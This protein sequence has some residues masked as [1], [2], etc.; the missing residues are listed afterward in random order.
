[1]YVVKS[2]IGPSEDYD[3]SNSDHWKRVTRVR[4]KMDTRQEKTQVQDMW[5]K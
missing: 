1:M 2:K 3:T 5:Y 4:E